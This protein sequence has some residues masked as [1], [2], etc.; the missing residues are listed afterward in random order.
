[1]LKN[2]LSKNVFIVILL[3]LFAFY[4]IG[5]C[6]SDS[7]CNEFDSS[8]DQTT[9]K[10]SSGTLKIMISKF[11]EETNV[12]NLLNNVKKTLKEEENINNALGILFY[13]RIMQFKADDCNIYYPIIK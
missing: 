8:N 2:M 1:M 12:F 3:S 10:V 4:G 7:N 9:I 6:D 5:Y 13:Y 11:K